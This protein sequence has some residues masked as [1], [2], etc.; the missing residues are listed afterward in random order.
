MESQ[1]RCPVSFL[2]GFVVKPD[3]FCLLEWERFMKR[4]VWFLAAAMLLGV[5]AIADRVE[6]Q[7][8]KGKTRAASTKHLMKGLIGANCGALKKDLD[9]EKLDWNEITLHAAM[10]NEAGHLLMDDG[11]CPDGEWAKA[12]KALQAQS[13]AVLAAAEKDDAASAKAAFAE[14]TAQSCK[15]C[16]AAHK[17]KS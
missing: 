15:V 11:R 6:A 14:L 16:H 8:T 3:F 1:P 17:P 4:I 7:K 2:L 12:A 9:A 5:F 10:L 13:A